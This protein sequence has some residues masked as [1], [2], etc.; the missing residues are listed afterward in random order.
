MFSNNL[1]KSCYLF[2][3]ESSTIDPWQIPRHT[4]G[5]PAWNEMIKEKINTPEKS[6]ECVQ[7]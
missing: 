4:S 3:W 6:A 5:N 1:S 2:L 7:I